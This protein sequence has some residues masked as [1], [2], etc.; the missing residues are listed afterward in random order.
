MPKRVVQGVLGGVLA[1]LLVV[2]VGAGAGSVEGFEVLEVQGAVQ[3]AA[4]PADLLGMAA[5]GRVSVRALRAFGRLPDEFGALALA[6]RGSGVDLLLAGIPEVADLRVAAEEGRLNA[7]PEALRRLLALLENLEYLDWQALQPGDALDPS[8]N[9]LMRGEGRAVVQGTG[10]ESVTLELTGP[11]REARGLIADTDRTPIAAPD[12]SESA[13]S[14]RDSLQA[15]LALPGSPLSMGGE[16]EIDEQPD[17]RMLV[18]MPY[19]SVAVP[20]SP[21]PDSDL[22]EIDL[23][24]LAADLKPLGGDRWEIV[25]QL[26]DR[27]HLRGPQGDLLARASFGTQTFNGVWAADLLSP[28]KL[29]A[30]LTDMV[31]EIEPESPLAELDADASESDPHRPGRVLLK[32]ATL[33]LDFDEKQPGVVTGPLAFVLDGLAIENVTGETQGGLGRLALGVDYHNVDL[34]ALAAFRELATNP[35]V[36]ME[37]DPE[38]LLGEILNALGGFETRMELTDLAAFAPPGEQGHLR[39]ARAAM[40]MGFMPSGG[41]N[42]QRDIWTSAEGQ[43]WS[44][45]DDTFAFDLDSAGW[46]LRVDRISPMTLLHLGMA[47]MMSGELA[48]ADIMASAREI[49]GGIGFGLSLRGAS[50]RMTAEFLADEPPYGLEHFEFGLALS[51]LDTPAPGA[52]LTYRHRGIEGFPMGMLPIPAPFFPQEVTL[53]LSTSRLPVGL[54]TDAA[55]MQAL[56]EGAQDPAA[57]ALLAMLENATRIDVNELVIDLPIAGLR[58]RGDVRVDGDEESQPGILQAAA[59][60][61]IRNL[62]ALVDLAADLSGSE[63]ERQQIVAVSTVLKLVGEKRQ[64]PEGEVVHYFLIQGNSLGELFVNGEDMAPLLMGGRP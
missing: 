32:G 59:E 42:H 17:G 2:S 22:A 36:L 18:V 54:F 25:L 5:E 47:S 39:V 56:R 50:G 31:L 29:D 13:L 23:G 53:D 49:L 37:R 15:L 11:V 34:A 7:D 48:E 55:R 20:L 24:T 30:G 8:A 21:E 40:G 60:L 38:E 58:F 41:D 43:G 52:S 16:L 61:E 64:S 33:T 3:R 12:L 10:G 14:L 44:F 35:E 27:V 26:P 6:L 1:L 4:G 62:D 19:L 63:Q 45:R 57:E 51:D 46:N 9:D 28:L